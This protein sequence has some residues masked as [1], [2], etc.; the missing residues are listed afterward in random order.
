MKRNINEIIKNIVERIKNK[1]R[2]EKIILFG[3]YA[4]G[5]P[6][7]DSDLDFLVIKES[8]LRRDQRDIEIRKYLK[9]I[10]FPMDIFVYTKQEVDKF[11]DL[12]GSFIKKILETGKVLYD[13][14]SEKS[15]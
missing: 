9:D 1:I 11:K 8:K 6:T 14:R 12:S 15:L 5:K 7:L 10:I 3:S 13:R 4:Q 2:P